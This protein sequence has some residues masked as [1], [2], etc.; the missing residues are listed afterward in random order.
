MKPIDEG[1]KFLKGDIKIHPTKN[2]NLEYLKKQDAVCVAV[3]DNTLEH[4]YLV[5]QYR[6]G[7]DDYTLEV[8]AGLIDEGEEP[9]F[10]AYRELL[11]ET[12]FDK[13]SIEQF[14]IIGN[15]LYVS[16]GY[17]TEKLYFYMAKLKK[18]AIAS[19]QSLDEGEDIEVIKMTIN[20]AL[21]KS[22]DLKTIFLLNSIG[23]MK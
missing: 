22:N 12:G 9:T 13:N 19:E 7:S 4:V 20:E 6:A 5:K 1:F 18:N 11:E 2:V 17:T 3:F 15:P 23:V 16:P 8:V 10:A 21:E 14:K